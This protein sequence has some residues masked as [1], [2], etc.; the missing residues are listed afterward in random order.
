MKPRIVS[1]VGKKKSGKTTLLVRVVEELVR[2]GYRVGTIKHNR[3]G[4]EID[5]EGTDSYRHFHAGAEVSAIVGPEKHAM[6]RRHE[7]EPELSEFVREHFGGVDIVV[8][9]GFKSLS[10]PKIETFRSAAH[11][12]ALCEE[13]EDKWLAVASDVELRV[14]IRRHTL[15]DVKGITDLI[16]DKIL[17]KKRVSRGDAEQQRRKKTRAKSGKGK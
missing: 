14:P 6:V 7:A 1:I 11:E 10:F 16:E 9:E 8:T 4:F 5:R 12:R 17:G 2:R 15:D 13:G 3:H